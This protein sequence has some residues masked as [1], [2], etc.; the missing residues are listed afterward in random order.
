M[1]TVR[2]WLERRLADVRGVTRAY[3]FGSFTKQEVIPND[4]DLV[5]VFDCL[6]NV[7]NLL[8][9]CK[10]FRGKFGIPLHIQKFYE[11]QVDLI[12]AFL[13]K[14]ESWEKVYG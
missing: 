13:Q 1:Q 4:V 14:A 3:V 11:Q 5:V 7:D 12:A 9:V 6:A 10:E 8:D 2:P